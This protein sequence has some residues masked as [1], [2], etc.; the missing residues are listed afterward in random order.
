MI[1]IILYQTT[2]I[3]LRNPNNQHIHTSKNKLA[4]ANLFT[5]K[6]VDDKKD[7]SKSMHQYMQ[8]TSH[9]LVSFPFLDLK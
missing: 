1:N 3:K 7:A 6:A 4:L 9:F 2:K 5:T 8:Q